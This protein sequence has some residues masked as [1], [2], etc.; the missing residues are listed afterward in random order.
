MSSILWNS[1]WLVQWD[2]R[3]ISKKAQWGEF[4]GGNKIISLFNL[5]YFYLSYKEL[6][7]HKKMA[8]CFEVP[9]SFSK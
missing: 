2:V 7:C 3:V 5:F 4:S 1:D 8:C 9:Q 6:P